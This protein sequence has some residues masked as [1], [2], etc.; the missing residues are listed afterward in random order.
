MPTPTKTDPDGDGDNDTTPSGDTDNDA[1]VV[2]PEEFQQQVHALVKNANKHHLAHM[3]D[4]IYARED[5]LRQAENA[6]QNAKGGKGKVN[7]SAESM[8]S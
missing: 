2:I 3:R 5:E 1:G 8:P 6:K 4:R 7:F